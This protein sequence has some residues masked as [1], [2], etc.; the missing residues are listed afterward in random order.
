MAKKGIYL[1]LVGLITTSCGSFQRK[2][3]F[4][5]IRFSRSW[6]R[7]TVSP[8]YM[9][10]N[11]PATVSPLLSGDSVI[12]ANGVDFLKAFQKKS[13]HLLWQVPI[14]NGAEGLYLEESSQSLFFGGNDGQFYN[15][16]AMT[17]QVR[18][19]FPLNSESTAAPLVMGGYIF[20]LAMNGSLYAFEK[21]SGRSIWVKSRQPKDAMT[22]RG[23]T[24]PQFSDGKV[25]VGYSD[26]YFIAYN[27]ADGMQLWEKRISDNKKFNDVDARPAI[28][29]KCILIANFTDSLYCLNKSTGETVWQVSEGGSAQPIVVE[30]DEVFFSSETAV[31]VIDLA[32]GKVKK[33]FPMPKNRGVPTAVAVYKSWLV[34]G[35]SEGPLVL[36]EKESGK[37]VDTFF[38]G[39]GISAPPTLEQGTSDVYVVSNQANLYKLSLTKRDRS[40]EFSWAAQE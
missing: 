17:G 18:W 29:S 1:F 4:T 14:K 11:Q 36:M 38:P 32:S 22:V 31:M 8:K 13:G 20:H 16:D 7:Q 15:V 19:N 30:G 34:F 2:S 27:A 35:L 26:G 10:F 3:D 12:E 25:Y 37:W 21:E 33:K 24:Q 23:T 9:G 5:D 39:R 40:K 28:T 6:S